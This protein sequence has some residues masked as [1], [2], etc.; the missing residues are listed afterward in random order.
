MTKVSDKAPDWFQVYNKNTLKET[1]D[2]QINKGVSLS[3]LSGYQGWITITPRSK[4][5]CRPLE[6]ERSASL[7]QP[8]KVTPYWMVSKH[9]CNVSI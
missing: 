5:R 7:D 8:S 4:N 3:V 6:M 9:Q 2:K 1:D